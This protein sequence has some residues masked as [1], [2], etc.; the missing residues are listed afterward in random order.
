MRYDPNQDSGEEMTDEEWY[1]M[2][3]APE[4]AALS[5]WLE[6]WLAGEPLFTAVFGGEEP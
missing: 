5:E 6:A 4:R 3:L 1:S 2:V